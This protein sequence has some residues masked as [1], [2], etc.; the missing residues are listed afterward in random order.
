MT[1]S[2]SLEEEKKSLLAQMESS[3]ET[4]RARFLRNDGTTVDLNSQPQVFPRSLLFSTLTRHPYLC[5]IS[6]IGMVVLGPRRAL[7][8]V[9]KS[10]ISITSLL[11]RSSSVLDLIPLLNVKK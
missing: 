4:Y 10:G 1:L 6:A 5:A 8:M 9:A 7:S 3:R 2:Q 11:R